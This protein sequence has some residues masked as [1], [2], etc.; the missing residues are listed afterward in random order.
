MI[1]E[2]REQLKVENPKILKDINMD[3]FPGKV[4][5]IVGKN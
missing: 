5:G 2:A 3:L 4:Y 1:K